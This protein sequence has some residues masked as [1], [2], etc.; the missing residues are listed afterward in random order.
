MNSDIFPRICT[1]EKN[2][3]IKRIFHQIISIGAEGKLS[4]THEKLT[5]SGDVVKSSK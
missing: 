3:K 1:E 4:G 5:F 2:K